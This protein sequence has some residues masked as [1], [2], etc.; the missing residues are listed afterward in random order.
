ML[1]L[2]IRPK[3]QKVCIDGVATRLA[4]FM[5]PNSITFLSLVLGVLVPVF[6]YFNMTYFAVGFL[7]L[8]GYCDALDGTVAR[9]TQSSSEIGSIFDI[10][11]DRVV[12]FSVVLGLF[13]INPAAR[14]LFSIIMLGSI[15]ICVTSFLVVGV[16]VEN[17]S[18]KGFFYSRGLMERLEAFVF[19][20]AMILMPQSFGLLAITFSALVLFTA[21]MRIYGFAQ[22]KTNLTAEDMPS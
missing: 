8:S 10:V 21:I 5:S 20:V 13:S 22:F 9:L 1:E 11:S 4:T 18:R 14:G 3:F 15:L 12:E 2:Y 17:D 16:F 6:L 19:F 7:L